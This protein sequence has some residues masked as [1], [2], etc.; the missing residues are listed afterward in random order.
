MKFTQSMG[1]MMSDA[2]ARQIIG[3][4]GA[5]GFFA[6]TGQAVDILKVNKQITDAQT[7]TTAT[8]TQPADAAAPSQLTAK[9]EPAPT[10][11]NPG[12]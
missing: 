8:L 6:I 9:I 1:R 10:P 12:Q 5:L 11:A 2:R 4:A 7:T 3:F